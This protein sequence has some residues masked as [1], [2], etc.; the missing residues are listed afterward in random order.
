MSTKEKIAHGHGPSN[1]NLGIFVCSFD[2]NHSP[3][4][5]MSNCVAAAAVV[6][7]VVA[8]AA[9]AAAAWWWWW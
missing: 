4:L 8:A 1:I 2:V 9:A 3:L 6:V 5:N 7:V